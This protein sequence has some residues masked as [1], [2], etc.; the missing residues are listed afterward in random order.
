[1][2]APIT[3]RAYAID[4]YDG[5]A[6]G[7]TTLI[8]M[9]GAG[10]ANVRGTA[11]VLLNPSA[12]AVR[13]TTDA[14]SWGIDWHLDLVTATYSSDYDNNGATGTGGA[15][16]V[17]TGLGGRI[18]TWSLAAT[19]T[20]QTTPLAGSSLEANAARARIVLG[21]WI[22]SADLAVGAGVQTGRFEIGPE[23][24]APALFSISGTGLIAGATW[25]PA[26]RSFRLAAAIDTPIDGG[27]VESDDCDPMDCDGYI[28]PERARAPARFVAGGA[29]RFAPTAWNQQ[30]P[31]PFRDEKALTLAADLVVTGATSNGYGLEAFGMQTLQRSGRHIVASLRGGLDYEWKPGKLRVRIGGYWE[32]GRFEGVGGRFH[33]TFGGDLRV[34]QFHFFGRRRIRISMTGDLASR[35]RNVG[36]SIGFWH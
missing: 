22:P 27:A 11:G 17:T 15:S 7:D 18:G 32:P 31:G 36:F 33:T 23:G 9:G 4:L 21:K 10:A 16:L 2:Q 20:G 5:V 34:L 19:G 24:D 25:L 29:Y 1:A 28:L 3:D 8:G 12:I 13:S 6:I 35:Y 14:S 26:Q 30:V